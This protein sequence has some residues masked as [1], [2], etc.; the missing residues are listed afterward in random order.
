[1][2]TLMQFRTS[3]K[4]SKAELARQVGTTVTTITK[5]E[6]GEW[7]I[8]QAVIDKIRE[9]YGVDNR[10]LQSRKKVWTSRVPYRS[11]GHEP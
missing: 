7:I 5:Y 3:R 1:M 2:Q 6:S 10:P 11:E 9:L 4:I 8:N